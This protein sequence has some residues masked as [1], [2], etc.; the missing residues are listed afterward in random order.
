[1]IWEFRGKVG[2]VRVYAGQPLGKMAPKPRSEGFI[3]VMGVK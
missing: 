3:D 1:M 2:E